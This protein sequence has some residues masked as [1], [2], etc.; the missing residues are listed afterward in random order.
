M[1][2]LGIVPFLRKK[3]PQII[4]DIPR[5]FHE[6]EG[7]TI[8]IDATLVTQRLHFTPDPRPYRHVLGWYQIIAELRQHNIKVIC[9]FDG[10]ERIPAKFEEVARR[11]Q[12]RLQAETRAAW[13]KSR[14][15]RLL[16]LTEA[17]V[18]L[19]SLP[20]E[21]QQDVLGDLKG[22]FG[23]GG[24]G[25]NLSSEVSEQAA[26]TAW[27]IAISE[28]PVGAPPA[29]ELRGT[30]QH[31][32]EA[33]DHPSVIVN[34]DGQSDD[35]DNLTVWSLDG[36]K[37]QSIAAN[38]ALGPNETAFEDSFSKTDPPERIVHQTEP[39]EPPVSRKEIPSSESRPSSSTDDARILE[40]AAERSNLVHPPSK[41]LSGLKFPSNPV[42]LN[43]S[44]EGN[45]V[46]TS[47]HDKA[48]F[49]A[50]AN[51]NKYLSKIIHHLHE[52]Y[53]R[54]S[55]TSADG[56]IH[57]RS[58]IENEK[59]L[60][61][62]ISRVQLKYTQEESRLWEQLVPR[63][64]GSKIDISSVVEQAKQLAS[65]DLP[66]DELDI[67]APGED[68]EEAA[69][70]A[71]EGDKDTEETASISEWASSLEEQ[72]GHMVASLTRRANPP[73]NSTYTESRLILEAMGVP[74]IESPMHY[75]AEALASSI[76]INGLADFVGSEDTDVLMYNAPLL[77]H[78][79]NRKVPLQIIPP[80]AQ[81]GLSLSRAAFVD[82]AI[83]MGTDFVR[84]VKKIGPMTAYRLMQ[85]YGSIERMLEAE[86]KL[87]PSDV[88]EYLEKVKVARLIFSSLPP[89]PLPES[90]MQGDWNEE[91]IQETMAH[92]G[93]IKYMK[94]IE[95]ELIP[96]ALSDNYF[97]ESKEF[98]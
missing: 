4:E 65:V 10:K 23:H 71:T 70:E 97:Q 3:C 24:T 17:L 81:N 22:Q 92:F 93:L 11:R 98:S 72:S 28:S 6:L 76:V 27:A 8:A 33:T 12:L 69:K 94:E 66:K 54:T 77:R 62:P 90:I 53:I 41:P 46:T 13:E 2:V 7:K 30:S 88:A 52:H 84:R 15:E 34:Q 48:D 57:T 83:L 36:G 50:G 18:N 80:D 60:D 59:L 38:E 64:E 51:D 91:A 35:K 89:A 1:G 16:S 63:S 20:Q 39:P 29:E 79:T 56:L 14:H 68:I 45:H 96:D 47:T 82:T 37:G 67:E 9:V 75:E 5:R 42:G 43:L 40:P 86:P 25:A 55:A 73:S 32:T 74:C 78:M 58:E 31:R 44:I 87:R 85:K 61:I 95:G 21:Q 19:E 26:P 49:P